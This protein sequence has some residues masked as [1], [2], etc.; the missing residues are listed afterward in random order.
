MT[1]RTPTALK[2]FFETGDRPTQSQF[3][4]VMDSYVNV[5]QTSGQTIIS[6]VSAQGGW[7]HRGTLSVLGSALTSLTGNVVVS[8]TTVLSNSLTISG[9]A[10]ASLSGNLAV[11]GA[12]TK[13]SHPVVTQ[14]KRQVFSSTGT[15]TPT[16]GIVYVDVEIVGGGGGG[17]G[18]DS[19][20]GSAGGGGGGGN[21][22]KGIF[23]SAQIG[24]SQTVTLG[25]AGTAGSSSGGTGGNGGNSSFGS[26]ITSVG[27]GQGGG[28]GVSGG[29][30]FGGP[31]GNGATGGDYNVQGNTGEDSV[32]TTTSLF[33][34]GGHGAN[35]PFGA[36][37]L[38]NVTQGG[39]GPGNVGAGHGSG[40][41][42]ATAGT[43]G[44][45][46]VGG[47]GTNGYCVV[48]EYISA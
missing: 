42:G 25:A 15:Y 13:N 11:T 8:G 23:T 26:L 4:D 1:A 20:A 19:T 17:G 29:D 18:C 30:A 43:G 35:S 37:G 45:G 9:S 33:Q 12:L 44:A 3:G 46:Q 28:G 48:T 16:S 36:G 39:A 40:G 24:A 6:D 47:A 22:A 10:N 38:G 31:G 41:G 7:K 21:Y 34:M 32:T 14:V 27:G 2:L 5:V